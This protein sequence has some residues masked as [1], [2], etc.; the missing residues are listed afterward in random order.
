MSISDIFHEPAGR[1]DV[2]RIRIAGLKRNLR[3]LH[4]TDSHLTEADER[5]PQAVEFVEQRGPGLFF[6]HTPNNGS[7]LDVFYQTLNKARGSSIQGAVL[8]GDIIDFPAWAG[9]DHVARGMKILGVPTLFTPGNHDWHLP[10]L[11][12]S[13]ALR[14]EYYPRLHG[15]TNNTPACQS[16]ELAGVRLITLDNSTYQISPEQLGFLRRELATGQPC[17][18]FIHIPLWIESL[19][20]DVMEHWGAPIMMATPRGW[21]AETRER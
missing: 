13:S 7:T 21:T 15:L 11:E 1:D 4:L 6:K 16:I 17:L 9:I 5:D 18:L 3:I 12:W 10:H 14:Q 20:S 8:I 19:V 2:A